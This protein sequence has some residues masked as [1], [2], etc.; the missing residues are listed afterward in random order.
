MRPQAM[1]HVVERAVNVFGVGLEFASRQPCQVYVDG[2]P[3]Q[4]MLKQ[5]DRRAAFQRK[6]RLCLKK[7]QD[8]DQQCNAVEVALIQALRPVRAVG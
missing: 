2:Q 3:W 1:G 5:V 8:S 6:A 7:R 4:A